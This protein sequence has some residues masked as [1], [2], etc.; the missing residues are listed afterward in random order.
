MVEEG[1]WFLAVSFFE[2]TKCVF[3]ITNGNNSFPIITPGHY[4]TEFAQKIIID[5]NKFLELKSPELHVEENR[6]RGNKIRIGDNEYKL[7][8]F[9]DQKNEILEELRKVK[10]NDL[11]VWF[12]ECN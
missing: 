3:N 9:D 1:K 4:Q 6:K 12:T 5:L 8:D 2:C 11:K 7:S 10:Y